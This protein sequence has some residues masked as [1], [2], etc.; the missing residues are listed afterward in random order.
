MTKTTIE[1]LRSETVLKVAKLMT[2]SSM[3]AP[4]SGGQLMRQG[5]PNF[6]ETTIVDDRETLDNLS[7]WM[8]ARGK[9]RR[10]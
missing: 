6:I 8:R 7:N 4:R 10:E 3:T 5:K 1:M 2:A 9:E